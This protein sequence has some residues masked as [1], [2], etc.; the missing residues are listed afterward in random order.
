MRAKTAH[1]Q[2]HVYSEDLWHRLYEVALSMQ[3]MLVDESGRSALSLH[4]NVDFYP[5]YTLANGFC[6][7]R[8]DVQGDPFWV[9]AL[10]DK[11]REW[12]CCVE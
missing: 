3:A 10:R 11:A 2:I 6:H 9:G 4:S 7:G 1:I 12:G 8:L 5:G